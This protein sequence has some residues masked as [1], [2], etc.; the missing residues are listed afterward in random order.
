MHFANLKREKNL[1]FNIIFEE[2][3]SITRISMLKPMRYNYQAKYQLV[4]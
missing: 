1:I 2:I 3:K 4:I